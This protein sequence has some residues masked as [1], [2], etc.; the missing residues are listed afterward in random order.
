MRR[1]EREIADNERQAVLRRAK[2]C[3]VAFA[4]ENEPYIVPLSY[5]YDSEAN[6]LVFHTATEG[7][8]VACIAV[9]PRVCFEVEGLVELLPGTGV[10][11]SWG[12]VYE[13]VIGY[14]TLVELTS[15]EEKTQALTCLMRHQSGRDEAWS[16]APS[17]VMATR[18]WRLKI[19][20]M[21]GKRSPHPGG[22][23]TLPNDA[24]DMLS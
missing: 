13:S 18:V 22:G 4:L 10:G 5:G 17:A 8:K 24:R 2:V 14:G 23:S 21:T 3:R 20:T 16:F 7:R 12:L 15:A 6:A 9:N 19:E 11:C 1:N